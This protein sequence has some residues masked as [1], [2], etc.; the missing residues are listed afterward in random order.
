MA[1]PREEHENL[2]NELNN[3]EIDHTRR[4]E[5]LQLL[6]VDY[7]TVLTDDDTQKKNIEKLQKDNS[8]LVVANSK[9]F[10]QLGI[11]G[12]E[13]MEK[14]EKEKDFSESITIEALEK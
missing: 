10:R 8:D 1:M 5:V 14:D 6:R 4:T 7:G 9:L 11:N 2:L 3:P 13:K 12:D